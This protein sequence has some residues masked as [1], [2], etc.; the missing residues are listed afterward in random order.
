V[1]IKSRTTFSIALTS[2][3]TASTSGREG[4]DNSDMATAVSEDQVVRAVVR[5][6]DGADFDTLSTKKVFCHNAL[7]FLPPAPRRTSNITS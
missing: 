3:W 7:P 5:I 6:L 4:P 1:L 2:F